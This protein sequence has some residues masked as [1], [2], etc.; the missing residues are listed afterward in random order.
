[1]FPGTD[2]KTKFPHQMS[3][4]CQ[5]CP[6][7]PGIL[8][9]TCF[10][11]SG[12]RSSIYKNF[13]LPPALC[14]FPW[15]RCEGCFGAFKISHS[16]QS[17]Q[18]SEAKSESQC[19]FRKGSDQVRRMDLPKMER[20]CNIAIGLG[21]RKETVMLCRVWIPWTVDGS[22]SKMVSNE[23]LLSGFLSLDTWPHGKSL[24]CKLIFGTKG[25]SMKVFSYLQAN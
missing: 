23:M 2:C 21:Q 15:P 5:T 1:M 18:G 6:P 20:S 11:K 10:H 13:P 17:E 25:S 19:C 16:R 7:Y 22:A 8:D 14:Q 4:L 24:C 12:C 3:K 9:G